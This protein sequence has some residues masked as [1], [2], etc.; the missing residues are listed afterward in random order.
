M[1]A[2]EHYEVV[3]VRRPPLRRWGTTAVSFAAGALSAGAWAPAPDVEQAEIRC[4]RTGE[5]LRTVDNLGVDV[6]I[7]L[8]HDVRRDVELLDA[9]EFATRW[10]AG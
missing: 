9:D 1:A 3:I 2:D 7:D 5:V 8:V 6:G 4:R 10:L